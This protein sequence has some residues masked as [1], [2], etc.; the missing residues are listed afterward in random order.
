MTE[1]RQPSTAGLIARL[2]DP[3]TLRK[4]QALAV[5]QGWSL[6]GFI[7]TDEKGGRALVDTHRRFQSQS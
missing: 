3:L 7:L 1:T 2:D 4:A 5:A 6:S